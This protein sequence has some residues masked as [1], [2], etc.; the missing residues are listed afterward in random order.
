MP[1]G[2]G[3]KVTKSAPA[4]D[5][6]LDID[7]AIDAMFGAD[8]DVDVGGLKMD[9]DPFADGVAVAEDAGEPDGGGERIVIES[10]DKLT[11][12]GDEI[13]P[14]SADG[15][16]QPNGDQASAAVVDEVAEEAPSKKAD[17][18]AKADKTEKTTKPE[19]AAKTAAGGESGVSS[20][21]DRLEGMESAAASGA[22]TVLKA[23]KKR[24]GEILVDMGILED[25][26]IQTALAKQKET[27]KR[28]GQILVEEKMVSELDLTKALATKFGIE[29]LDLT[30][31]AVD[32][33]A[34]GIISEKLCRRYAAIP[35]RFADE[36]TLLVAMVDPAN[37][38]AIDDLRIMTGYDI[39]PAIASEEDIFG[40]IARLNKLDS[41]VTESADEK[42]L[43]DIE[44]DVKDIRDA[45]E[46]AP[47][48]KLVNAVITQSVDDGASD[49]HFEPQAKDLVVRFRIDGVLHEI[50]QVP[51][52]MQSGVLSRLKIMADLDIAERRVPQDGRIE[53]TVG[54]KQ[55]G[56]ASCRE[57][58]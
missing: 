45:T 36:G 31:I 1:Q 15:A 54:G 16:G 9:A 43:S 41:S 8:G 2:K 26:Q 40:A 25:G 42:A 37:V 30:K 11:E 6:A 56:R 34:A 49:I 55:I 19:K 52:R 53:L 4:S 28:L 12:I 14:V 13:A 23:S 29:Y 10:L 24:I 38:L 27:R 46:E 5:D 3:E 51:R 57:R 20:V 32:A 17:K 44:E 7:S 21:L 47:I 39:S 33:A 48:V 22:P 58:V 50:M 35:V 18:A